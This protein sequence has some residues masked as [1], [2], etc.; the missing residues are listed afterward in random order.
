MN[1]GTS[2]VFLGLAYNI[3]LL[4]FKFFEWLIA[5]FFKEDLQTSVG[6]IHG[7]VDFP[8]ASTFGT[9]PMCIY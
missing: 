9:L 8:T 2:L 3:S 6:A 1:I 5:P 7:V 4:I